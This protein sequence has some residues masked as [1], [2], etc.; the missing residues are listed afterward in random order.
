MQEEKKP[1]DSVGFALLERPAIIQN[2]VISRCGLSWRHIRESR[3]I[4]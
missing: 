4:K 2:G 3:V 1:Q